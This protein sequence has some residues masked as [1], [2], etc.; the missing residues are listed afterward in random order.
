M[1]PGLTET[2]F[3]PKADRMIV[4]DLRGQPDDLEMKKRARRTALVAM[5]S[6]HWTPIR[7]FIGR[8]HSRQR[9]PIA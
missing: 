4:S 6:A 1:F 8:L 7:Q 3:A 2:R 9:R 5:L